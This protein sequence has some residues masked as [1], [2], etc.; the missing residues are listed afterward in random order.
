MPPALPAGRT[1]TRAERGSGIAVGEPAGD[2]RFAS[3][4]RT[5]LG[6]VSKAIIAALVRVAE[7]RSADQDERRDAM[8][9][10]IQWELTHVR[11]VK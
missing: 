9:A 2:V 11:V 4:S 5:W 10:D 7:S 8:A 6:G 3:T 1:V